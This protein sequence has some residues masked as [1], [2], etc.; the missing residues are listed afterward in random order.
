MLTNPGES[1]SGGAMT[2]RVTRWLQRVTAILSIL[3]LY[4]AI[5][6]TLEDFAVGE[7]AEAGVPAV[8]LSLVVASVFAIQAVGLFWLGSGRRRGYGAHVLVG[9]FWPVASGVAQLPA[10][11]DEA[12]YREGFLSVTYVLG[13]I[14][15]GVLLVVVSLI[16]WRTAGREPDTAV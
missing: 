13:I 14:V 2:D 15:V 11:L 9:A 12:T 5:P 6:H 16:G 4:F 7:P 10:I 8:V 1:E 3:L